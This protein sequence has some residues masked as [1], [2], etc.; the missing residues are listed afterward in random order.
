[1]AVE[2]RVQGTGVATVLRDR[3]LRAPPRFGCVEAHA[4]NGLPLVWLGLTKSSERE[5]SSAKVMRVRYQR[6]VCV[7][8]QYL[9]T[10]PWLCS[11]VC[12][13]QRTAADTTLVFAQA[14]T[15]FLLSKIEIVVN[16][17]QVYAL[18]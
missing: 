1:M 2:G 10:V 14:S 12:V 11:C 9:K 5:A 7:S 17:L 6:R 8:Q 18:M 13:L 16:F 4:C 3:G 15:G